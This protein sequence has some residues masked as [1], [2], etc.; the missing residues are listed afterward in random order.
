MKYHVTIK[1]LFCI[2]LHS[3]FYVAC[4]FYFLLFKLQEG[5]GYLLY[6][7]IFV[8][9]LKQNFHS[10]RWIF[11]LFNFANFNFHFCYFNSVFLHR[12]ICSSQPILFNYILFMSQ[13]NIDLLLI[14]RNLTSILCFQ[15][16]S[17]T[18]P[19]LFYAYHNL[20]TACIFSQ[21]LCDVENGFIWISNHSKSVVLFCI[22][23]CI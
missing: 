4:F 10:N 19:F 22:V 7:F 3:I 13:H 9:I 5:V 12:I 20:C 16:W 17:C 14:F 6:S 15:I 1:G 11:W 2:E 21:C 8:Q 23:N 18:F